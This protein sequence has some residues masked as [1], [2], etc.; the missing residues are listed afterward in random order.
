MYRITSR[1]VG[2]TP[3]CMLADSLGL[4]LD[5]GL[6]SVNT[7]HAVIGVTA[8]AAGERRRAAHL[9]SG[10]GAIPAQPYLNLLSSHTL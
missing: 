2:A 4:G 9:F 6:A 1:V 5:L 10:T 3:C 7:R 8:G